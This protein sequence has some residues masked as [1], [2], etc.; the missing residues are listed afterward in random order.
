GAR[1]RRRRVRCKS[2]R[3]F[4]SYMIVLLLVATV[5][6]AAQDLYIDS[7]MGLL[8]RHPKEDSTRVWLLYSV[9]SYVGLPEKRKDSC[10]RE[11]EAL[12]GRINT[13]Y[14]K[15]I[16]ITARTLLSDELDQRKIKTQEALRIAEATG[17]QALIAR[18]YFACA[19]ALNGSLEESET[20]SY[21]LK[22]DSMAAASGDPLLQGQAH[23]SLADAYSSINIDYPLALEHGFKA[24]RFF[25]RF[26]SSPYLGRILQIIGTTYSFLGDSVL[27]QDY[28]HRSLRIAESLHAQA[29]VNDLLDEIGA[30]Y[31]LT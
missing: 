19:G 31:S 26:P 11:L 18:A 28:L 12:A 3:R 4:R 17:N 8:G 25:E 5:P 2:M 22:A 7:L 13:P 6:A 30:A 29:F 9:A 10:V 20:V 16:A 14:A 27:A 21:L 15:I 1:Q 23:L 24:L